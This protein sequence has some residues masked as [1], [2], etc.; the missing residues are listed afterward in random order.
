MM[1][2]IISLLLEDPAILEKG[3]STAEKAE[4]VKSW[5]ESFLC[6][7]LDRLNVLELSSNV[8]YQ[9]DNKSGYYRALIEAANKEIESDGGNCFIATEIYGSYSHP[10]VIALRDFAETDIC[11]RQHWANL[12]CAC[13]IEFQNVYCDLR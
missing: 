4:G 3:F 6:D 1:S 2:S 7:V 5:A 13:T 12:L 11:T 9:M 8:K 10:K